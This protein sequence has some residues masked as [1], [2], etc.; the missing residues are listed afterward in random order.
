MFP[1]III[2]RPFAE[3]DTFSNHITWDFLKT[4]ITFSFNTK[5][6]MPVTDGNEFSNYFDFI[7]GGQPKVWIPKQN[8]QGK[9]HD[10]VKLHFDFVIIRE[11]KTSGNQEITPCIRINS[12]IID[13]RFLNNLIDSLQYVDH[14]STSP[15]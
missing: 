6:R 7:N 4:G 10:L 1:F 2:N 5:H 15:I 8:W 3:P 13:I 12:E 9:I 11:I 14:L